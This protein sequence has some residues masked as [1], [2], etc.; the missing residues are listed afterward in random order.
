MTNEYNF[1]TKEERKELGA[2][3]IRGFADKL[4]TQHPVNL[5][6]FPDID[7]TKLE[8]KH[9]RWCDGAKNIWPKYANP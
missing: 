6:V 1:L 2:L 9:V 4:K 8:L 5:R 7:L 3:P